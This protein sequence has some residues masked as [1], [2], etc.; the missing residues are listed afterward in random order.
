MKKWLLGLLT[1]MVAV[2]LAA[3]TPTTD[4][5]KE[6]KSAEEVQAQ[7]EAQTTGGASDKVPDPNVAP[8]AI[9]SVYHKGDG[10]SLVQDMDSLDT[11]GLD[12]QLLVDKLIEYGVLTDG[13]EVLSFDIEGKDENAVGTLDLNQAESAEGCSDKMF[14][15]EI[16]NTFTE[17]FELSKLKLKVNGGN[18]E[19]DD[20]K[21]GDSDYLT[22]NADYESV[23]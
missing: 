9:I 2:S 23:E 20:I 15:T 4:K 6:T 12:A 21:Q 19:G 14:L 16:G 10:D 11:E 1:A 17:N 22:Y 13:T 8:V 5:Q 3:C 18:Y 7:I